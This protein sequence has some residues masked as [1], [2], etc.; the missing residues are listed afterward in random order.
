MHWDWYQ[1][2]I[3]ER[4]ERIVEAL[5]AGVPYPGVEEGKGLHGYTKRT[6]VLSAGERVASVLSGGPNGLPNA[7]A[8]GE[9]ADRFAAVVRQE[10]PL[11][12]VTRFDSCE[13]FD[14]PGYF[15]LG[16]SLLLARADKRGLKVNHAGDWHRAIDGRTI[17]IGSR[18]S[19]VQVRH[20]EKGLQLRD[21]LLA[22]HGIERP[23]WVRT[24]V[25][26]RP[27]GSQRLAAATASPVEAW[28]FS[29]WTP[30]VLEDLMKQHVQRAAP[31]SLRCPDD[32]RAYAHMIRQY[33]GVLSRI[34]DRFDSWEQIGADIG[35][36]IERMQADKAPR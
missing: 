33:A 24:E 27:R 14:E 4:P 8:S 25:Q 21:R 36:Q 2:T 22:I 11:H 23:N 26:V 1:A 6:D 17:Y 30:S 28:G 7:W 9:E 34:K 10:F 18:K 31:I 29:D 19:D 35:S 20:Y 3:P 5:A 16:V 15:D 12:R 32:E 13:D